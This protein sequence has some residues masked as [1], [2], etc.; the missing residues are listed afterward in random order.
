MRNYM[1]LEEAASEIGRDVYKGTPQVSSRVQQKLG[2]FRGRERLS[3]EYS[4]RGGWPGDAEELVALG[5]KLELPIFQQHPDAMRR[6]LNAELFSRVYP[7]LALGQQNDLDHPSLV[8]TIEGNWP[9]YIYAERLLGM[10]PTLLTALEENP[11]TRRAFWPIFRPEDAIRSMAPTRVP[12]SL[13]YQAL[14]RRVGEQTHLIWV[15]LQRS[16]DYDHFWLSDVWLA[17]QLQVELAGRLKVVPGVFIHYVISF[18]SFLI[19]GQE[20]Y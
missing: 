2:E 4:I 17:R 12:C 6:W 20:V 13:G 11:D 8:S 7:E 19:E 14:L 15:Y 16:A 1:T 10:M 9:S 18:H 5:V 3:Y